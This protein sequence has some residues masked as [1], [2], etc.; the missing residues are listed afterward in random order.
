MIIESNAKEV[1]EEI[2]EA[3]VDEPQY[4]VD[5][6]AADTG[7][8]SLPALV[9]DRRCYLCTQGDVELAADP[10]DDY[11]AQIVGHCAEAEDYL[12][13]DTPLKEAIFRVLISGGNEPKTPTAVSRF[14]LKKW[15][16]AANPRD[17]SPGVVR[18]LMDNS[19]SYCIVRLPEESDGDDEGE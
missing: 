16:N 5:A 3:A 17:V 12:L 10:V 1:E 4:A 7:S 19:K 2:P 6:D 9:A 13:S 15:A 8:R 18:R 14:L 11:I